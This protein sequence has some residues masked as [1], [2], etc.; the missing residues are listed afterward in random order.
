MRRTLLLLLALLAVP[1]GAAPDLAAGR[2]LLS[3]YGWTTESG[4][5]EMAFSVSDSLSGNPETFYQSASKKIGLDLSPARGK[6]ATLVR[7]TMSRR[8]KETHSAIY[9]HIAYF[10]GQ[11]IGAWLSADGPIAPGIV[12]LDDSDFG[13]DF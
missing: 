7:Y 9:A 1:A 3:H 10:K 11:I 4:T 12:P 13:S 6:E 8:S 2:K 5:V